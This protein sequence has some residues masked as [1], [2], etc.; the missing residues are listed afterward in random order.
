MNELIKIETNE[1]L[2]PIISG[3]ELHEKLGVNSHYKDWIRRMLDYGFTENTDYMV[4]AQKRASNEIKGFTEYTDHF[5]KLDMAKE[6]CM[7]QRNEKGKQFRKYFIQVEKDFNSPEKI[8]ARA[9]NIADRTLATL[10]VKV[11][12]LENKIEEDRPRVSFAETIEKSSDS[13]LI[14]EFSKIL[15]NEGIH[16]GQNKLY[17]LLR[18]WGYIIKNSTEPTQKAVQQGLFKINERVIKSVK[19]DLLSRTTMLTGKGQLFLLDKIK[20]MN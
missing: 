17:Q 3:R 15:A 20:R 18:E 14:R 11:K 12:Q 5:L 7:L 4:V 13:I 2:E 16:I 9:L 1:N 6:I 8:M 10:N 19:G